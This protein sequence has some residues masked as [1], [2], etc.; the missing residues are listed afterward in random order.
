MA[1]KHFAVKSEL[2][3][4][5]QQTWSVFGSLMFLFIHEAR[6]LVFKAS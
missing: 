4:Q 5:T 2:T 3:F 1:F 6:Q